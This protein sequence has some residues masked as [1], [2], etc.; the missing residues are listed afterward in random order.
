MESI[1]GIFRSITT[2]EQALKELIKRDIPE[3]SL[4]LLSRETPQSA[5]TRV[6]PEKELDNVRTTAAESADT[7]K[8][9]G[10]VL[11]GWT[12]ATA[13]FTAGV[14]AASLM[15]PGL[16]LITAIG[17]GAAALLGL[18]GAAAGAKIGDTVEQSVDMGASKEQVE[19]YHQLLARGY[20][21]VI[22]NVRSGSDISTVKEVFRELGS[23]DYERA[24]RE[25]GKAA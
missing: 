21:L 18:G 4:V 20:S 25:V 3:Q 1:L 6:V 13:G 15:V 10:A 19:F 8:A 2:A 16:G 11:G 22:A 9:A 5:G 23:E 7:G 24:R 12:G 17:V 14:T